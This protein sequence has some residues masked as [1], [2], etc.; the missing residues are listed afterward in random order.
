[1]K[2]VTVVYN[3]K[4]DIEIT[5][6]CDYINVLEN[7]DLFVLSIR[8]RDVLFNRLVTKRINVRLDT[9]KTITIEHENNG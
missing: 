7:G 2:K 3:A 1:M 4:P 8:L 6:R 5:Y 9:V